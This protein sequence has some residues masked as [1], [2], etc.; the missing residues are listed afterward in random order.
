[1]GFVADVLFVFI[2]LTAVAILLFYGRTLLFVHL[3]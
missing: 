3:Q 2:A 1:M